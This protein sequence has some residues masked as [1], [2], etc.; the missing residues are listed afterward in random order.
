[1]NQVDG[2]CQ[3][4]ELLDKYCS[5][6][7]KEDREA[8]ESQDSKGSEAITQKLYDLQK[9]ISLLE[10]IIAHVQLRLKFAG[11]PHKDQTYGPMSVDEML[12]NVKL[13]RG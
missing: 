13:K 6:C 7:A 10:D 1:M 5:E 11:E 2:C 12:R 4:G 9:R 3:H 8:E